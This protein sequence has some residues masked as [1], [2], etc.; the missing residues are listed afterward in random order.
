MEWIF[1]F[2]TFMLHSPLIICYILCITIY[3]AHVFAINVM[4]SCPSHHALMYVPTLPTVTE[5][6]HICVVRY[7]IYLH[8]SLTV[9]EFTNILGHMKYSTLVIFGMKCI[10]LLRWQHQNLPLYSCHKV[11]HVCV[12][13][14][15]MYWPTWQ[16]ITEVCSLCHCTRNGV[17]L[18]C[19]SFPPTTVQSRLPTLS[20]HRLTCLPSVLWLSNFRPV[21]SYGNK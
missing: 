13:W 7:K 6:V 8:T 4:Y 15:E 14:Y 21:H 2:A 5:M 17:D 18:S 3:Q 20:S 19:S 11:G 16:T 12:I 9:A 10:H 1:F